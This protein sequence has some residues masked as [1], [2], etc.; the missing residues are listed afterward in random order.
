MK[1]LEKILKW[2][3]LAG[4]FALPFVP[5][6]VSGSMFFPYITGKNFTFRIIVEIVACLWLALALVDAKYRPRRDWILAAFAL[7]ILIIAIADAQGVNP[8]K[9][10]WSNYERMDGWVTIAHLFAY[11]VTVSLVLDTEKLWRMIFKWTMIV[12]TFISVLGLL[13]IIGIITLGSGGTGLS[14]R[15]DVTFGNP[16]YLAVYMLFNVFFAALLSI[17]EGNEPWSMRERILVPCI[18]FIGTIVVAPQVIGEGHFGDLLLSFVVITAILEL[19][20]IGRRWWAL[21]FIMLADT[22]ALF[23][24][25]TRGTVLGL[26]GGAIV[27]GLLYALLAHNARKVRPYVLGGVAALVVL[28]GILWS[29]RDTS[30]VKNIGFLDRLASI[31]LTDDTVAARFLNMGIAWKGVQER[32]ILGWGQENYAIVFDKYYDPRM[33]AQ[34]EWFDRVHNIIFDWW[35]AGGTLGL[36]AYL[37][38]FAATVWVLWRR[39]RGGAQAFTIAEKSLITGLLVGYFIHNLTVFDN[40]TSYILWGTLLGYVV[41]RVQQAQPGK[42]LIKGELLNKSVLPLTAIA[43]VL[44]A[45]GLVWLVNG[46]AYLE[47]VTLLQALEPQQDV[48]TNLAFFEKALGYNTYGNQEAREQLA[49]QTASIAPASSAEV[50][51]SLKQQYFQE[52]IQQLILQEKVSPLDARNPLFIGTVEDA[53]GDYQDAATAFD[54]AHQLSPD[55]QSILYEIGLNDEALKENTQAEAVFKQAY[56]LD[57][58]DQLALVYYIASAVRNGD[59]ATANS[60]LTPS[61]ISSGVAADPQLAAAYAYRNQ[62]AKIIPIWTA[63][64]AANPSDAQAYLTLAVAYYETHDAAKAISTLQSLE[65]AVPDSASQAEQFIQEIKS[66]TVNVQ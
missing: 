1:L 58:Q 34:E 38:V 25:G 60:L 10:F 37:S 54:Q 29:A 47:N 19:L 52:A 18:L 26:V 12:S 40:V 23:F 31:S 66:G 32:P 28:S 46:N 27:A 50:P 22:A 56:E 62:Y 63:H 4:V 49:Q 24:T 20:M 9:S 45:G 14:S 15:I 30:F 48:S 53:Y 8:V 7:F 17:Q 5:L 59:D 57:T 61:L 21:S 13:Q 3:V 39:N 43:T 35:I 42:P 44:I 65:N 36:L 16:I 64:I 6:I 55:K 51:D 11:I 41:W 2:A 33:Y